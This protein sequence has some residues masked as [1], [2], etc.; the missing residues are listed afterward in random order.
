[1]WDSVAFGDP[2]EKD[3][4][5]RRKSLTKA[6]FKDQIKDMMKIAKLVTYDELLKY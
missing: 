2:N 1:M 3:H 4:L 6:F 5:P